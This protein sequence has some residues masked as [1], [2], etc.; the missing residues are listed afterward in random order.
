M[1][2]LFILPN[3]FV[4]TYSISLCKNE[5]FSCLYYIFTSLTVVVKFGLSKV[6]DSIWRVNGSGVDNIIAIIQITE[7]RICI[8]SWDLYAIVQWTWVGWTISILRARYVW[9][10]VW[11]GIR[12]RNI[13]IWEE[14][15]EK[16][17]KVCERKRVPSLSNV[18]RPLCDLSYS[19]PVNPCLENPIMD[20][21]LCLNTYSESLAPFQTEMIPNKNALSLFRYLFRW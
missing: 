13:S 4:Y 17:E 9:E 3:V 20:G 11:G 6:G 19:E 10:S 1:H 18:T 8:L 16:E 7:I 2:Q 14:R 15:V 12:V 21:S 5:T